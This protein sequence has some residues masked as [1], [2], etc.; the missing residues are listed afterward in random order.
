M[1]SLWMSRFEQTSTLVTFFG[2]ISVILVEYTADGQTISGLKAVNEGERLVLECSLPICSNS[3]CTYSWSSPNESLPADTTTT[4]T[5]TL[6]NVTRLWHRRIIACTIN[7]GGTNQQSQGSIDVLYG[8]SAA[9]ISVGSPFTVTEGSATSITCNVPACNPTCTAKWFN[10]TTQMPS[11]T[12]FGEPVSRQF[13]GIYTCNVSNSVGSRTSQLNVIVNYGPS[14]ASISV[15]SPFTVTEGSTTSITCNVPAC[16]PTCTAK[17]FNGTTQMPSTTLFGTPVSRQFAGIYTCNVSNSVGSRTSQLNVI[18]NYG[19]SA[20]SISVGSPFTVTE[21]STTSITCNAPACNP[22]CTAKWFNGSTQILLTTLFG[23]PVSRHI[24]GIYTCNVSNSVGYRTSQLQLI[25]NYA[26]ILLGHNITYNVSKGYPLTVTIP[27]SACPAV[28]RKDIKIGDRFVNASDNII[29]NLTNSIDVV[30]FHNKCIAS[31]IQTLSVV[32]NATQEE[33][34]RNFTVNFTNAVDTTTAHFAIFPQGPPDVPIRFEQKSNTYHS[35]TFVVE[36]GFFNGGNQTFVLQYRQVSDSVWTNGSVATVGKLKHVNVSMTVE[37]L[38]QVT[39]YEFRVYAFNVYGQSEYS[40]VVQVATAL[41]VGM[42]VGCV[43][44]GIAGIFLIVLIVYF[45]RKKKRD[46]KPPPIVPFASILASLQGETSQ[47]HAGDNWYTPSSATTEGYYVNTKVASSKV[48]SEKP[49]VN[50]VGKAPERKPSVDSHGYL[51]VGDHSNELDYMNVDEQLAKK[52]SIPKKAH[53]EEKEDNYLNIDAGR[54][55]AEK[56]YENTQLTPGTA[57]SKAKKSEE[58]EGDYI[59]MSLK[60]QNS[61]PKYQAPTPPSKDE[62]DYENT[63]SK[64]KKK[65]TQ[66][67]S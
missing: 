48:N 10:G 41:H 18:V 29:V 50:Q 5:I 52:Q 11:T 67:T 31:A 51:K 27:V 4:Q 61:T 39:D 38:S 32:I 9:S 49:Y 22:T 34:F 46:E 37:S 42:V 17:W 23:E 64:K 6:L 19:P 43:I 35:A 21:G 15:G 57:N 66:H 8:P 25:V 62:E 12:L 3:T 54:K 28:L 30:F 55:A 58:L 1:Y 60:K 24:A 2:F 13:A 7:V 45:I 20:A 36:S 16:N 53:K 33:H 40:L 65:S 59:E 44:G 14:A 56:I 63:F 47:V 26:P